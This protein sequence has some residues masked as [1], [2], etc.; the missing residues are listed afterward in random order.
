MF[1]IKQLNIDKYEHKIIVSI[2]V[3]MT[4]SSIF[5]ILFNNGFKKGSFFSR[6]FKQA[7]FN[8]VIYDGFFVTLIYISMN[9]I[10]KYI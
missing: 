2:C 6:W 5:M 9:F 1:F 7:R 10:H 8:A 3:T 4:I